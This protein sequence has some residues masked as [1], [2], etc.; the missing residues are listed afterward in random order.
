MGLFMD[1]PVFGIAEGGRFCDGV[2][3]E[4]LGVFPKRPLVL[5]E[6]FELDI[7]KGGRFCDGV[8]AEL[9][10]AFP[11]RPLVLDE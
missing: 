9:L 5:D 8:V 7:A 11:K 1:R 2:V 4:L 3:A 10:G 6:R